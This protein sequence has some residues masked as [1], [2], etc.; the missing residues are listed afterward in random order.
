MIR[1][2]VL[3]YVNYPLSLRNVEDLLAERGID[4]RRWKAGTLPTGR[5]CLA[6]IRSLKRRSREGKKQTERIQA[7]IRG[8]GRGRHAH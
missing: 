3:L 6:G 5:E 7:E 4:V 1:L 2:A 8:Q